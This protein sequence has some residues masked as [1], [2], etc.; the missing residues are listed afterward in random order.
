MP[1]NGKNLIVH[2]VLLL[3]LIAVC[4]LS[5]FAGAVHVP[6]S[7]LWRSGIFQ[8]RLARTVLS[9]VAGAALSTAG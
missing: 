1:G 3:A 5:L 6:A 7:E 9:V 2:G 4:L 8:L